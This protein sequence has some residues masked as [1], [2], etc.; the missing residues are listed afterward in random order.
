MCYSPGRHAPWLLAPRR[1]NPVSRGID[2]LKR[3]RRGDCRPMAEH[4]CWTQVPL[5]FVPVVRTHRLEQMA[6]I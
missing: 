3:A 5:Q 1:K 2:A 4:V 6:G